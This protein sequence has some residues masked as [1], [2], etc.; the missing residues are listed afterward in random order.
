L[1][2]DRNVLTESPKD[3]EQPAPAPATPFSSVLQ[4]T[5]LIQDMDANDA[6]DKTIDDCANGWGGDDGNELDGLDDDD[7]LEPAPSPTKEPAVVDHAPVEDENWTIDSSH[8][9]GNPSFA[10]L[11]SEGAL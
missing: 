5:E 9:N 11:C 6:M 8:F 2:L 7:D 4:T 1:S 3:G 10:V